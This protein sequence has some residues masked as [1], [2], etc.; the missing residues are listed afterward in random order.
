MTQKYVYG[1]NVVLPNG[2]HLDLSR[3]LYK[4]A[5]GPDMKSFIGSEG[6]LGAISEAHIK[7][8]KHSKS[9]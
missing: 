4:D 3:F 8:I 7:L 6:I 9:V 1:L 5:T 2:D